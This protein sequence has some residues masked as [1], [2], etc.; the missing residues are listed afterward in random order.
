MTNSTTTLNSLQTDVNEL[1]ANVGLHYL[2]AKAN[3]AE[4]GAKLNEAKAILKHGDY[5]PWM[6]EN[7]SFGYRTAKRYMDVAQAKM[8]DASSCFPV[9]VD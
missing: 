5:Q 8:T 4:A 2:S 3:A 7:F 1:H 6:E 9:Y